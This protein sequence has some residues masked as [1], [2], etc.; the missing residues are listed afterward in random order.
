[1]PT[2]NTYVALVP[3]A[4]EGRWLAPPATLSLS[5]QQATFLLKQG[6]IQLLPKTNTKNLSKDGNKH[7]RT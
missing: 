6:R 1:M 4:W 5:P 3:F 2:Q 7:D